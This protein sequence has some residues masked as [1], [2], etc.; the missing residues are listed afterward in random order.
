ME[1]RIS[2]DSSTRTEDYQ[3][4]HYLY[5]HGA[6]TV[7]EIVSYTGLSWSEVVNKLATLMNHGYIEEL[8]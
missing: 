2:S 5:E 3:V 7:Q 1:T 8:A 6:V 4:L